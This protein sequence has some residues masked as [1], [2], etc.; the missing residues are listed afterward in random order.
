MSI[1]PTLTPPV[2]AAVV[3]AGA[4]AGVDWARLAMARRR[5][6]MAVPANVRFIEMA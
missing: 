5:A 4:A 6:N 1:M 3:A 2:A